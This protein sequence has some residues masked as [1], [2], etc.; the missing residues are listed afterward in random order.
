MENLVSELKRAISNPDQVV[1]AGFA[2][3]PYFFGFEPS[4]K[5]TNESQAFSRLMGMS[6]VARMFAAVN[7]VA[8][9]QMQ[10]Q[11]EP[12]SIAKPEEYVAAFNDGTEA[13]IKALT[14]GP[15]AGFYDS[16]SG[17]S[18]QREQQTLER[19]EIHKFVLS[20]IFGGLYQISKENLEKDLDQVLTQ[21]VAQLKPFK[22][23]PATEHPALKHVI[24]V[25]YV[26]TTDLSGSGTVLIVEAYTRMVTLTIEVGDWLSAL[27]KPKPGLFRR[28]EKINFSMTTTVV[29]MKLNE[30]K[31]E[32]NKP[33]YEQ[34][35]R[36]MVGD[37]PGL[38]KILDRG[39][40]EAYGRETSGIWAAR[41]ESFG[42]DE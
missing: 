37:Q 26:K 24:L 15:L 6:A 31:Y 4:A 32:A 42:T 23:C 10:K 29:E 20:R 25:N 11:T 19:S 28:S 36:L 35:L 12:Y 7:I 14:A 9:R 39:G 2:P 1:K 30:A 22:A 17:G 5:K 13:T 18:T 21:F 38:K 8:T 34:T 3:A 40:L 41:E 16:S 33:R 27:Q